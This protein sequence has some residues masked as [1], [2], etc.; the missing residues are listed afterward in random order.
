[1]SQH[2]YEL[3][4]YE[5]TNFLFSL[6][7]LTYVVP[8]IHRE[9]EIA[10][11]LEGDVLLIADGERYTIH[12]GEFWLMNA[13]QCHELYSLAENKKSLF[14][15]L[16]VST[17]FFKQ[18]FRE[19][20]SIHMDCVAL[21]RQDTDTDILS[22]LT[23]LLT[24]GARD[25]FAE[26]DFFELRCASG[27]NQLLA[28]VLENVPHR[29]MNEEEL[30]RNDFR[31][32]RMQRITNYI[33]EHVGEKLLLSDLAEKEGLTLNYLS[34]F[35]K[36]NFGMPFQTYLQHLRC[37]RAA[38]LLLETMDSPSEISIQCGFS[39]LK[40]MNQ[41]FMGLYGCKPSE[42]RRQAQWKP[43]AEMKDERKMPFGSRNWDETVSPHFSSKEA[44]NILKHLDLKK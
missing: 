8:H 3:I 19:I 16:Q 21:N 11:V 28:T 30:R 42:Y 10:M 12:P 33:E 35:F 23:R 14:L 5:Q 15:L 29:C 41:G 38:H 40:Y 22:A 27:I 13:C 37:R 18:Y 7:Q 43:G 31:M 36:D 6:G 26:K 4:S 25:Y 24:E 1:M 34:H 17:S 2:A 9:M 32:N 44:L 20:E 39:A